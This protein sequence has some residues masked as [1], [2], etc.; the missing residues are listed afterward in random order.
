MKLHFEF[1]QFR[2]YV[3]FGRTYDPLNDELQT[4]CFRMAWG[5]KPLVRIGPSPYSPG[6]QRFQEAS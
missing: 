5:S 1:W 2:M 4:S 6:L 3:V